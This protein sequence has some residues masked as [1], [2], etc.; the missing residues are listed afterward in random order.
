M[1]AR[2]G[3]LHDVD[4]IGLEREVGELGEPAAGLVDR[5]V[6]RFDDGG[7]KAS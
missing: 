6:V 5:D 1:I 4:L 2:I 3:G 7:A